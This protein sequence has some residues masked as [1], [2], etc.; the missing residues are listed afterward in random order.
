MTKLRKA[1]RGEVC[2][3]RLPG[4]CNWNPETTVLAHIRRNWNAGAGKKA[5]D[6]HAVFACSD[7]HDVI[8]GRRGCY[9]NRGPAG[10]MEDFI[11]DAI[12]R[13]LDRQIELG[14]IEVKK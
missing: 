7:C 9:I 2:T 10:F 1:A 6:H 11:V 5:P 8:D 14:N 3:V 12:F 13:T 4:V